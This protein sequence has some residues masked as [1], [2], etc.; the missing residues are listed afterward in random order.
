MEVS[1]VASEGPPPA[2]TV[3]DKADEAGSGPGAGT[4][5]CKPVGAKDRDTG[6]GSALTQDLKARGQYLGPVSATPLA[7]VRQLL[8]F[9]G[10]GPQDTVYDIGCGDGKSPA[11]LAPPYRSAAHHRACSACVSGAPAGRVCVTAALEFDAARCCGI[12]A[13]ALLHA[14]LLRLSGDV[15]SSIPCRNRDSSHAV[16]R[17]DPPRVEG[18]TSPQVDPTAAQ[19]ARERVDAGASPWACP[20]SVL[21]P[22]PASP[23]PP[24]VEPESECKACKPRSRGRPPGGHRVRECVRSATARC[25]GCVSLSAAL[26]QPPSSLPRFQRALWGAVCPRSRATRCSGRPFKWHAPPCLAQATAASETRC[27]SSCGRDPESSPTC[28]ACHPAG[29][30]SCRRCLRRSL[31]PSPRSI[32]PPL[33]SFTT[34]LRPA[35]NACDR[36]LSPGRGGHLSVHEAVPIRRRGWPSR[37][38]PGGC[39]RSSAG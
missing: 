37:R 1:P 15:G 31:W 4:G 21:C 25:L 33:C 20:E 36:V 29:T 23:G 39:S 28:S 9:A 19:R 2:S 16:A 8:Q 18:S 6:G 26:R 35:G 7:I 11:S 13:C 14:A 17:V 24:L 10:V 12:E 30:A 27:W 5:G 22:R 38:G 3:S 32:L 34:R